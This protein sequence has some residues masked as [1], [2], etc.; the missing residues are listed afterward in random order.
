MCAAVASTWGRKSWTAAFRG[1]AV[2]PF[3]RRNGATS[4]TVAL[5]RS[6]FPSPAQSEY[7]HTIIPK[8]KNHASFL[9]FRSLAST[10]A[11]QARKQKDHSAAAFVAA[12]TNDSEKPYR[13]VIVESPSKCSTIEKILKEYAKK[14]SLPYSFVVTSCLGHVR[15]LPSKDPN[16]KAKAAVSRFPYQIA[17]IDLDNQYEP[18][19]EIIPGKEKVVRDLQSLARGADK[20]LLAT[21]P[22]REG[23][24]MAW[25]LRQILNV[26]KSD[27]EV[28]ERISFTEITPS[29]VQHAVKHPVSINPGLVQAQET[30]RILDRLAGFTVSPLLWKKI[31]P[32]LS[33]GRVQSVG[34]A[35]VVQRERERLL[36]EQT[37]YWSIQADFE[38]D[39]KA[40]GSLGAQLH[41]VDGTP[42]AS[43][44]KDFASQGQTL[45][46]AS[47]HKLHLKEEKATQL[48]SLFEDTATDWKVVSV[49]ATKRQQQPPQPYRTSTLQ[50][51]V[52]RRL[53]L[54]V[55]QCMRVAQ[56]LYENGLIS[57]MRT[58]STHISQDAEDSLKRA[59]VASFGRGMYE[60]REGQ[61]SKRK[62]ESKFAQEAHE[63]IRPAVQPDGTFLAPN[64][65]L[66][67]P[68][69]AKD[70]Y[71]MIYQRTLACRMP[72][73]ITNLTQVS[74]EAATT[75]GTVG[76]FR[77]SG[78]VV[79]SPGYTAAYGALIDSDDDDESAKKELPLLVEGQILD[80]RAVEGIEHETQPP[81][82]F[83]EASFVKELEALGV[84]R[85]STYAGIVKILR[86]RAYVGSPLSSN[87]ATR[88]TKE[89]SGPAISAHRAAGGDQ[90][91]G[92]AKG[93]LV[94]SLTAF[95]VCSLLEG[96]CPNYVNANFTA[97]MEERLDHIANSESSSEQE[98]LRYL[99]EFYA[100]D[101]GLASVVKKVEDTVKGEELRSVELPTLHNESAD[102]TV[103]LLV[104]PWGPYIQGHGSNGEAIKAPVPP[105]MAADLSTITLDNLKGILST[106]EAGGY[107]IGFHPDNGRSIRLKTGRFGPFLQCGD[108]GEE[109]TTTH[110]LPRGLPLSSTDEGHQDFPEDYPPNMPLLTLEEAVGYASLPRVVA[111]LDRAPISAAIGP[112]GP[113]LK[114]NSTYANIDG[115]VDILTIDAITAE[116]LMRDTMASGGSKKPRGTLAELGEMEGSMVR[117]KSGRFGSYISW[118]R[119]NAKL[120]VEYS[121]DNMI[122]L[123]QAWD[124][125]CEKI[126]S[127]AQSPAGKLKKGGKGLTIDLPTAPKR[128]PSAY[129]L[130][131]SA[132]RPKLA[133]QKLSLAESSKLLGKLWSE[134]PQAERE[135]F[136]SEAASYKDEYEKKKE[137]WRIE[138]ETLS[139][140]KRAKSLKGLTTPGPKRPKSAYLFF[141][142]DMRPEVSAKVKSLGEISKELARLWRETSDRSKYEELAEKDKAR[143]EKE[144][145]GVGRSTKTTGPG[146]RNGRK[147]SPVKQKSPA[148]RPPSAYMLF[149][150]E[151][152]ASLTDENGEKLSLGEGSKR[153]ASMWKSCDT[154]TREKFENLALEEKEK[155]LSLS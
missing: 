13:L 6:S 87:K 76:T 127:G 142:E 119:T 96:H 26:S 54:G 53:G 37:K 141:C 78:S 125:V 61:P 148:K 101:D 136:E 28:F 117:V 34:M 69:V 104:G 36:F 22:D 95:V 39:D 4:L 62:K 29:A 114:C 121:E 66:D 10:T 42:V 112:Y 23:E 2:T 86:E 55:D 24:A 19:Y 151:F 118:K 116:Q 153:L 73:L 21:D 60:T 44:G 70:L 46:E 80:N 74:I 131:C 68:K 100:G 52:N 97:N 48:V 72:N 128:P 85:P 3:R 108:D 88:S 50:Q 41:L 154:S 110:S 35:L 147:A 9:T 63:A 146:S 133:D 20:I 58:D 57:Y 105:S 130:F 143:Y 89:V 91:T 77:T 102:G 123:E 126:G 83:T 67:L 43:G 150:K 90:F 115:T 152:R 106:K 27:D 145:A 79:I 38:N 98:R 92:S 49:K 124:L 56:Q 32:G 93:S 1:A 122:S 99:D 113:Y 134:L 82:R 65:S 12:S 17:G 144:K 16:K 132:T 18:T 45:I 135:T 5:R 8:N 30:R 11:L 47:A 111:D 107:L 81:P 103:Q 138:C 140:T 71:R 15:N 129:V 149:C 31:A 40:K 64:D 51:D 94:P 84:G 139:G 120:P 137:A 7:L 59:V 33:A 25:H 109:G 14:E 75:N 155:M